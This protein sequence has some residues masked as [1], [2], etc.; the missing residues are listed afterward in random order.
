MPK[1]EISNRAVLYPLPVVLVSCRDMATEKDN[2]ITVAW[3]GIACSEPLII[4]VSIRPSRFS[5]SLI[6]KSGQLVINLPTSGML[7]KVDLCGMC[8]GK[9]FDKFERCGFHPDPSSR[10]SC[11]LIRE[12]PVNIECRLKEVI[13]LGSHD[14]FLCAA[15]AVQADKEVLEEDGSINIS[16]ADPIAYNQGQY[17]AFGRMIGRYG[18]SIQ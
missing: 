14:M 3:C 18:C 5:S 11:P 12:C 8:S 6:K 16:R 17:W 13:A 4:A 10:V 15:V 2:I 1:V 7:A 9:D